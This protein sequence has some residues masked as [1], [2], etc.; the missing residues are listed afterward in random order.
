MTQN[1]AVLMLDDGRCF[2]GTACGACAETM[3]EVVFVTSM[4]GYQE[5]ISDPSYYGQLV[6]FTAA[7]IGNYGASP[8]DDESAAHGASGVIF[9]ELFRAPDR[10]A[11][12]HWRAEESLNASLAR[13]GI[14]GITEVDTRS[15]TLHLRAHGARNG[16]I[17]ALDLDKAS[18]L[19]RAQSLPPMQG[20][21][22]TH[23]VTC[24]AP[25]V[26]VPRTCQAD[27][28]EALLHVAVLDFGVKRS[29]LEQLVLH[30]MRPMIWPAST[31]A[32]VIR[33]SRPAGILLSNGPGDPAACG[34]AIAVIRELLGQV[35]IFGICLG[36]QLLGLCLG[37]KTYKLPFGHHGCNHPVRDMRTGKVLITSQNHGFCLDMAR[38]PRNVIATHENLNDGTLEG[39][40]CRDIPAFSVQFH[41]EAGPGPLD[42]APLFSR[43][44]ELILATDRR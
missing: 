44:R 35:P 18:L 3:G 24:E 25:H 36:H 26:Y 42:A 12:P 16:I 6:A 8:L 34:E 27:E 1:R 20:R 41:P 21:D 30:G 2:E 39:I 15:L 38:L 7:H 13:K 23:A 43:F 37:A 11:F 32:H 17:S 9:H 29:I 10:G 19:R 22:L 40:E 31:P 5:T 4:A 14:T 28:P 33:E